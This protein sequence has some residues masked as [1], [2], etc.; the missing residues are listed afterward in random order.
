L[1]PTNART[2]ANRLVDVAE[3]AHEDLDQGEQRAEPEKGERVRGP[4]HDRVARHRERRRDRVDGEGDVGG[5]HG[6]HHQ[7]QR[8][9]VETAAFAD[10]Q[11]TPAEI[12]GGRNE[13]PDETEHGAL[14]AGSDASSAPRNAR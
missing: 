13:T 2:S 3:A 4:D 5:D 1:I 8:R 14:A 6:D 10:E 12:V 7:Q 9:A 11:P